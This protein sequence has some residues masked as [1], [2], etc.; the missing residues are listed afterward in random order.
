M[1]ILARKRKLN[2]TSML[3]NSSQM[4][5]QF[6]ERTR[7]T[8]KTKAYSHIVLTFV[9]KGLNSKSLKLQVKL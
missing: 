1:A 2:A 4:S 9:K 6:L 8:R 3:Q 5:Q 7:A